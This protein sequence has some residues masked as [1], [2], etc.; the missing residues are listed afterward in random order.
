MARGSHL[1]VERAIPVPV[2]RVSGIA[3]RI[4]ST[5]SDGPTKMFGD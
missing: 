1:R 5:M 4:P 2:T 3:V